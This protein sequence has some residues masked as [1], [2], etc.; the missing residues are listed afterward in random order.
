MRNKLNWLLI[1]LLVYASSASYGICQGQV[2]DPVKGLCWDCFFPIHFAGASL[3]SGSDS[4]PVPPA[5]CTCP[6]PPPLFVRPGL[7]ISY[8]SPDRVAEVVREPMCSPSL[9]GV[10]L[11]HINIS[12]GDDSGRV[13]SGGNKKSQ[14]A[15]FYVHWIQWPLFSALG[16]VTGGELCQRTDTAI[17]FAWLSEM[18]PSWNDDELAFILAPESLLFASVAANAACAADTLHAQATN[19]GFDSLYWCSGGHGAVF[20]LSGHKQYYTGGVDSAMN[21]SHRVVFKLHRIGLLPDTSTLAALCSD[22]PQPLL[23][24]SQYK[25]QI[26]YPRSQTQS[27]HGFGVPSSLY[28]EGEEFPYRGEDWSFIVWRKHLCCAF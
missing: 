3:G 2:L 1:C 11:G 27:A 22:V 25:M 18:D 4:G 14:G 5:V 21:L 16:L 8:W 24:K 28:E 7:G 15:F 10:K 13:G 17:D 19:F 9:G 20:P 12:R 6:A 23:R 26:E